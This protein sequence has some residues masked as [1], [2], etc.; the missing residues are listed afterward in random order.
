LLISVLSIFGA[1]VATAQNVHVNKA[2]TFTDNG[3]TLTSTICFQGLGNCD[4]TVTLSVDKAGTATTCTNKGGNQ[5]PGQ[6]PGDVTVAGVTTVPATEIDNGNLCVT[7]VT[8]APPNPTTAE[9]G[10]P[11]GNW[12]AAITDVIF[13]GRTATFTVTQGPACNRSAGPFTF[14]IPTLSNP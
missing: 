11:S 4:L 12:K 6:N 13:S 2:P 8:G 9:A 5:A 7:V 3:L 1:G 10:C 14:V